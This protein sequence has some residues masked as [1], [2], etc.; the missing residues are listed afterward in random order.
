MSE[1]AINRTRLIETFL[2]LL[3]IN[4]PSRREGAIAKHLRT[5]LE[6]LG[7]TVC[8]DDAGEHLGGETGNLIARLPGNIDAPPLLFCAH[9]DTVAPTEGLHVQRGNGEIRSDGATILG[10]DD[11]AGVAAILEMLRALLESGARRPPLEIVFTVA[12]EIGVMGSMLLDYAQLTARYGFVPDTSGPVGIIVTRA[13]AQRH[14]HITIHGKAAHAGMT[15]EHGISAITVAARAIARMEQGRID[16]ETTA[17]IGIM[18]GGKATN[19]VPE[20]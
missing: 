16:E 11:R 15:P 1:H 17:N 8:V 4:A 10:A 9:I 13:P 3:A 18:H 5:V 6:E 12:E 20:L 7:L 19:I 2:T 14:L